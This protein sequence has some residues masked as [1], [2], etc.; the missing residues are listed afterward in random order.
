[1][2]IAL[3]RSIMPCIGIARGIIFV[4]RKNEEN[5]KEKRLEIGRKRK[6]ANRIGAMMKNEKK[7]TE[8]AVEDNMRK[9]TEEKFKKKCSLN[10]SKTF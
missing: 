1:M 7:K 6:K 3:V 8:S 9:K 4:F 10:G 5:M 2:H